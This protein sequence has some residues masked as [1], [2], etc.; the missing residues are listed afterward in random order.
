[1][2]QIIPSVAPTIL[3][4]TRNRHGMAAD[5]YPS[6]AA[7]LADVVRE[8]QANYDAPEDLA[9]DAVA[10]SIWLAE[11]DHRY[12]FEMQDMV[13]PSHRAVV[14]N[15][16]GEVLAD[17]LLYGSREVAAESLGGLFNGL[18]SGHDDRAAFLLHIGVAGPVLRMSNDAAADALVVDP[19]AAHALGALEAGVKRVQDVLTMTARLKA[20]TTPAGSAERYANLV[21]HDEK[22]AALED[23]ASAV[24]DLLPDPVFEDGEIIG[25]NPASG[26][27]IQWGDDC[28]AYEPGES[29]EQ[30]GLEGLRPVEIDRLVEQGWT[31]SA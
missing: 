22:L 27:I 12:E 1:M 8:L 4:I 20:D 26:S 18:V 21:I 30:Y 7:A 24:T 17:H 2:P 29:P 15:A 14:Q 31:R 10:I 6:E 23:W 25:Y 16:A 28:G 9:H 11:D 5:F 19:L 3:L 13:L